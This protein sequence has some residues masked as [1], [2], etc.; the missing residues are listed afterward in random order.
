MIFHLFSISLY[1]LFLCTYSP[2][3]LSHHSSNEQLERLEFKTT[4]LCGNDCRE[5]D[6]GIHATSKTQMNDE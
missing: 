2:L 4:N 6:T 1:S 5:G 3:F